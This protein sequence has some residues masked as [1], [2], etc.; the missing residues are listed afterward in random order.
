MAD[1]DLA[2]MRGF[3]TTMFNIDVPSFILSVTAA[4]ADNVVHESNQPVLKIM[5]SFTLNES[6]PRDSAFLAIESICSL[7]LG[8]SFPPFLLSLL[9][10]KLI[11][12]K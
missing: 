7:E 4:T 10:S 1:K 12:G 11:I 6:Y 2:Q 8:F 3:L 5:W 9:L